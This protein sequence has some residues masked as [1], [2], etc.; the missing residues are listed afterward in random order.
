MLNTE[1]ILQTGDSSEMMECGVIPHKTPMHEWSVLAILV[2]VHFI[3]IMDFMIMMPLGPQFMRV[4]E[5]APPQFGFLE[6]A[7]F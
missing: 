2:G 1:D 6:S 7:L 3:H 4:F 5:I